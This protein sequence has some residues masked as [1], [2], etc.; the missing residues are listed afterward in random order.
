MDVSCFRDSSQWSILNHHLNSLLAW[1]T[2]SSRVTRLTAS[3]GFEF[4]VR[5]LEAEPDS[6]VGMVM[7]ESSVHRRRR[8]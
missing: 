5:E 8:Q 1:P 4:V 7:R 6:L 3:W 2:E